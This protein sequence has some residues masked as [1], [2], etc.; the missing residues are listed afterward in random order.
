MIAGNIP[1]SVWNKVRHCTLI[2]VR[3]LTHQPKHET[4]SIQT[5]QISD[6]SSASGD[7]APGRSVGETFNKRETYQLIMILDCQMCGLTFFKS[8]FDGISAKIYGTWYNLGQ[9]R[10]AIALPLNL[11]YTEQ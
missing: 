2:N 11:R 4:H 5:T 6:G 8:K 9:I 10:T 7:K 3:A 1:A